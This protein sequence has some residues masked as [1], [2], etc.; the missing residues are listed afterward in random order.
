MELLAAHLQWLQLAG[1]SQ[2][3]DHAAANFLRLSAIAKS[4]VLKAAR[5]V[6]F[7]KPLD[8]QATVEEMALAWESGMSALVQR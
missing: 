3:L 7:K 4:F 2:A 6:N 5:A 8:A 1:G